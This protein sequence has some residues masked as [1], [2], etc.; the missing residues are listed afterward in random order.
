VC[1]FSG[2]FGLRSMKV[3]PAT[4]KVRKRASFEV[5]R[6]NPG[7]LPPP[8]GPGSPSGCRWDP[9]ASLRQGQYSVFL[10]PIPPSEFWGGGWTGRRRRR[11]AVDVKEGQQGLLRPRARLHRARAAPEALHSFYMGLGQASLEVGDPRRGGGCPPPPRW[12]APRPR[13]VWLKARKISKCR[14]IF[15][16]PDFGVPQDP[17]KHPDPPRV[18][19]GRTP[20]PRGLNKKPGWGAILMVCRADQGTKYGPQPGFFLYPGG[21]GRESGRD[22]PWEGWGDRPTAGGVSRPS[23]DRTAF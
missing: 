2:S 1:G 22:P 10:P 6:G 13:W 8:I 19:A 20:P 16:E 23:A 11:G 15:S 9:R 21:R 18:G 7:F 5:P 14:S 12:G 4:E 3:H 17:L